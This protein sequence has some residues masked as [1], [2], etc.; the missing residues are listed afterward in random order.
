[1]P[2]TMRSMLT[3]QPHY[4]QCKC[5]DTNGDVYAGSDGYGGSG[6]RGD[7][8]HALSAPIT[9]CPGDSP[10]SDRGVCDPNTLRC[11]CEEGFTGGDCSQRTCKK[12]RLARY[13]TSREILQPLISLAQNVLLSRCGTERVLHG[14]VTLAQTM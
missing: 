10:C 13:K 6:D 5:F 4:E 11:T 8:G 7:C 9:T 14:L 2:M 1:M 12:V 3:P